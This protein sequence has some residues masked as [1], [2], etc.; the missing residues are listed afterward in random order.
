[1]IL[2]GIKYENEVFSGIQEATCEAFGVATLVDEA[3]ESPIEFTAF[4]DT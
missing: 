4:S 2:I 3:A 1:V